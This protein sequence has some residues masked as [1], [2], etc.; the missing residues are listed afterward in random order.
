M[1]IPQDHRAH[2]QQRQDQKSGVSS[3]QS[4]NHRGPLLPSSFRAERPRGKPPR[5]KRLQTMSASHAKAPEWRSRKPAP[6]RLPSGRDRHASHLQCQ[7]HREDPEE[8][9][10]QSK[11]A[12]EERS[13]SQVLDDQALGQGQRQLVTTALS[14]GREWRQSAGNP[15]RGQGSRTA[16]TETSW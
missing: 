14:A 5:Q 9:G 4:K 12:N 8:E 10:H 6:R 16:L 1:Y 2:Q 11:A 7:R 15:A 3:P 13:P